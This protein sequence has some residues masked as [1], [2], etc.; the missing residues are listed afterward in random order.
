MSRLLWN[1]K[2]HYRDHKDSPLVPIL[3]QMNPA[4]ILTSYISMLHFNITPI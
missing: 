4:Y 3:T 1:Q 2:I